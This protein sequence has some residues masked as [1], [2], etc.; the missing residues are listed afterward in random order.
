MKKETGYCDLN[1]YTISTLRKWVKANF[2]SEQLSDIAKHG[3][4]GWTPFRSRKGTL[5][6]FDEFQEEF[7]AEG[8]DYI[9]E[10]VWSV[11][12]KIAMEGVT[13]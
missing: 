5:A 11:I 7:L 10:L 9:L 2:D 1:G 6:V 8:Q 12:E 4:G 3:A 13:K